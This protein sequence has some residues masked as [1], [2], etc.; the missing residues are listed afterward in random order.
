M[1]DAATA[2]VPTFPETGVSGCKQ[3]SWAM[4]GTSTCKPVKVSEYRDITFQAFG[5]FGSATVVLEGSND[6]RA[7]PDHAD[8]ASSVWGT[9]S[10]QGA[11]AI[12]GTSD[13]IPKRVQQKPLWVRPK[14]TGGTSTT[15]TAS[16]V[17]QK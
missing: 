8:Y 10:D 1:A 16:L 7:N 15:V 5:T 14:S 6:V 17:C 13:I 11:T 3:V 9:L 2:P 12:S 4:T